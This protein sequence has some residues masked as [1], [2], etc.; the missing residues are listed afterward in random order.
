MIYHFIP[1]RMAVLS[2]EKK[3]KNKG[4]RFGENVNK[5]ELCIA[6]ENEK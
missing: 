5:V 3:K 1:N 6:G 4:I 2:Y